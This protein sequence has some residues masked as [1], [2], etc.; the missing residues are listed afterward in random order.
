MRI[1]LVLGTGLLLHS[2]ALADCDA[3]GLSFPPARGSL[4]GFTVTRLPGQGGPGAAAGP[5]HTVFRFG[6]D[7]FSL[8]RAPGV[9]EPRRVALDAPAVTRQLGEHLVAGAFAP[10]G[11][12]PRFRVS[13]LAG[14]D[15]DGDAAADLIFFA[16]SPGANVYSGAVGILGLQ[17]FTVVEPSCY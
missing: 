16:V 3:P 14:F 15:L 1:A 8:A 6:D 4:H 10:A 12:V 11:E 2:W 17:W 9:A 13:T 5:T 7:T